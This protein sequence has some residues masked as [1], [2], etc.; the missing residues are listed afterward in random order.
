MERLYP[1]LHGI[2]DTSKRFF[3]TPDAFRNHLTNANSDPDPEVRPYAQDAKFRQDFIDRMRR[4][5]FDAPQCWYRAF[6]EHQYSCDKELT[7]DRDKVD[8]PVLY[9][10]GKDDAPCR[11][12]T[13][14]PA[15]EKGW[16]PMLEEKPLLDAAH[17]TP[18][19]RP[20]EVADFMKVWL[21]KNYAK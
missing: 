18:Y 13:M 11:V 6:F 1:C 21:G 17:W 8:V 12:E 2:G 15:I 19:E 4:D 9:V 20:E 5:R 16:L 7:E 14:Y 10:G 3:C